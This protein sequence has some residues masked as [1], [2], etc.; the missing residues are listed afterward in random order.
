MIGRSV[1]REATLLM[2]HGESREN[3]QHFLET[4]SYPMRAIETIALSLDNCST[5][6]LSCIP[7]FL[8]DL[9]S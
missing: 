3:A 5:P 9:V 2:E 1:I 4:R 6:T 8:S 7:T